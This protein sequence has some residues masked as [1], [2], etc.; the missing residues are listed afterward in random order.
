M[1]KKLEIY[2][3]EICGNIVE[4]TH[5]GIGDLLC[6]NQNMKLLEEHFSKEGNAHY[7]IIENSSDIQKRIY[8]NHPM[9]PEHYIE[10][11]EVISNDFKYL[12]RKF[13]NSS[14]KAEISFK[15]D[16]KEGYFVR[17]YCNIDGVW[18][19]K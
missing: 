16:C 11:I 15:C 8:F 10:Y 17:L 4:I 1:T 18:I 14:D 12:K 19:T 5:E 2:K 6:C 3:C 13:L 7:A 9:T